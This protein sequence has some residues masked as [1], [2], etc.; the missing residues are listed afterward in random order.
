[1]ASQPAAAAAAVAPPPW[2]GCEIDADA[3]VEQL[4]GVGF[5]VVHDWISADEVR[6]QRA[7]MES[8]P[9]LRTHSPS[10]APNGLTVRAHTLLGKTRECDHLASDPRLLAVVRGH[11]RDSVQFSI[12]TLMDILPGE[13]AQ[14]CHRVCHCVC[15][16]G[17]A[18]PCASL[19]V[20]LLCASL[21]V[22]L[23][24]FEYRSCT[25][26]MQCATWRGHTCRSPSTLPSHWTTSPLRTAPRGSFPTARTGRGESTSASATLQRCLRAARRGASSP[27]QARRGTGEARTGRTAHDWHSTFTT[28]YRGSS[29]KSRKVCVCHCACV[30][31]CARA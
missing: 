31:V 12:C 6:R 16:H 22:S 4:D 8:V 14:V 9:V 25:K 11:L 26:T 30:R 28:A 29:H 5:I 27:G 13:G 1:M 19:C 15:C 23:C 2:A 3:L 17:G 21:C 10:H 7:A 18:S 24:A 20:S